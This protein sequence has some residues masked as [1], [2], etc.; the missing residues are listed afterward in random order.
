MT[1]D[2]KLIKI[3]GFIN[4]ERVQNCW[5][6]DFNTQLWT[7]KDDIPFSFYYATNITF[8][9]EEYIFTGT[10]QVWIYNYSSQLFTRKNDIPAPN[11]GFMFGF[12]ENNELYFITY[13]SN[14][15]YNLSS[16]TWNK[17]STN[18]FTPRSRHAMGFYA[19][20]SAYVL[21]D[22]SDLYKYYYENDIW[23]LSG[24]FPGPNDV[25]NKWTIFVIDEAAY[26]AVTYSP[27]LG[28]APKL[29][30]YRD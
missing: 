11:N 22:G 17:I 3:G 23:K 15:K 2:N 26:M 6:Y 13:G 16:D 30:V 19:D 8:N 24:T 27:F 25:R 9:N 20:G 7:Q 14:W 29:N 1:K 5:E 21:E 10:G 12:I 4:N 18:I 28:Q